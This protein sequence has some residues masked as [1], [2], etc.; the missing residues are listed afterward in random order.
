MASWDIQLERLARSLTQRAIVPVSDR[1][2]IKKSTVPRKRNQIWLV[3]QYGQPIITWKTRVRF[4]LLLNS[5]SCQK[6]STCNS[7]VT[8]FYLSIFSNASISHWEYYCGKGQCNKD[9]SDPPSKTNENLL[10]SLCA[11]HTSLLQE[12]IKILVIARPPFKTVREPQRRRWRRSFRM[13]PRKDLL[14][15]SWWYTI[16]IGNHRARTSADTERKTARET[17]DASGVSR[18]PVRTLL[19]YHCFPGSLCSHFSRF[20]NFYFYICCVLLKRFRK[21]HVFCLQKI[22]KVSEDVR[23]SPE[24][25]RSTLY[26]VT[27]RGGRQSIVETPIPEQ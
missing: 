1:P 14:S 17:T 15:C 22:V 19:T 11:H 24:P 12:L 26:P 23:C 2:V 25:E 27:R 16:A 4:P 6:S 9:D 18:D 20:R 10:C 21:N 8:F 5:L 13:H 7:H 3:A